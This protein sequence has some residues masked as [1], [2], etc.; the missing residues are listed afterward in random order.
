MHIKWGGEAHEGQRGRPGASR[1]RP[2]PPPPPSKDAIHQLASLGPPRGAS[3][4]RGGR[5]AGGGGQ[6]STSGFVPPV[7]RC[8]CAP[9]RTCCV[10]YGQLGREGPSQT[11]TCI[12]LSKPALLSVKGRRIKNSCYIYSGEREGRE[13][14]EANGKQASVGV[15]WG[16][17][18]G[19]LP[20]LPS[21]QGEPGPP[22][23]PSKLQ[24][25]PGPLTGNEAPAWA[26]LLTP[27]MRHP[28]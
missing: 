13:G 10:P 24:R 26:S 9:R 7:S 17:W 3:P 4:S 20:S 1:L 15:G 14:G 23:L 16:R 8:H 22:F 2:L 12:R 18:R 5:R 27:D 11:P 28:K 25:L 21:L 19:D 6:G